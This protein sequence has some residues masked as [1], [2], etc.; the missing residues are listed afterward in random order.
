V[1]A[2]LAARSDEL[3]PKSPSNAESRATEDGRTSSP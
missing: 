1:I 3:I 2:A